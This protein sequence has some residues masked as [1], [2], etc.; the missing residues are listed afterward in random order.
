MP[1]RRSSSRA[2]RRSRSSVRPGGVLTMTLLTY[3]SE[4]KKP[5]D[6]EDEVK[7]GAVSAEE[8]KLA[9]TLIEAATAKEFDLGQYKDEYSAKLAE[10]VEGKSRTKKRRSADDESAGG[11]QSH[12]RSPQE[13]GPTQAQ[14]PQRETAPRQSSAPVCPAQDRVRASP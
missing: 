10:L 11:H 4:M 14:R 5:G 6:F 7:G 13:P 8:R 3:E 2:V 9:E 12:G 1:S